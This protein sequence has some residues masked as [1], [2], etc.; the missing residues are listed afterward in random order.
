[1]LPYKSLL[2]PFLTLPHL[3][4]ITELTVLFLRNIFRQYNRILKR[5]KSDRG[6]P[7]EFTGIAEDVPA[8]A[9]VKRLPL[10]SGFR[11][12]RRSKA[13]FF[14]NRIRSK[15]SNRK[16]VFG[17]AAECFAA[18]DCL[19]EILYFSPDEDCPEA[20]LRQYL[21]VTERIGHIDC[22]L[23]LCS[24]RKQKG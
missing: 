21:S 15:K 10:Q 1:M 8:A 4:D 23:L 2:F 16:I 20:F 13:M 17:D 6:N 11:N 14:I 24:F 22:L 12:I 9:A 5:S 7:A 3:P 19:C 18:D